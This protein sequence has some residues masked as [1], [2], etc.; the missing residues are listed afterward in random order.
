MTDA[1]P[2]A[3]MAAVPTTFPPR[4]RTATANLVGVS[5]SSSTHRAYRGALERLDAWLDGRTLDDGALADRIDHL[6]EQ[7]LS[8]STTSLAVAAS[9]FRARMAGRNDPAEPVTR[10]TL[11][12][13]RRNSHGRGCGQA[14]GVTWEEAG[15]AVNEA[16]EENTLRGMRDAALIASASDALLRVSEMMAIDIDDIERD[17]DGSAVLHIRHSKTDQEGVGATCYLGPRTAESVSRY[18]APFHHGSAEKMPTCVQLHYRVIEPTWF[19][20]DYVKYKKTYIYLKTRDNIVYSAMS[21]QYRTWRQRG[22]TTVAGSSVTMGGLTGYGMSPV[23]RFSTWGMAGGR[24][25]ARDGNTG[26]GQGEVG[27]RRKG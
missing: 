27:E 5:I 10:R 3:T 21:A 4:F 8:A 15:A 19:R 17:P 23:K 18:Q 12:G 9:R 16:M 7:G 14:A 11:A 1:S 13:I 2:T 6:G 24:K 20:I 22:C 26:Q 25:P